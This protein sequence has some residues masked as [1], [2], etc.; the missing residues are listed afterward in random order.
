MDIESQV[1]DYIARNLIFSNKGFTYSDDASFLEEG[2]VD[3]TGGHG[4]IALR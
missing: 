3:F 2:I 4:I 1:K